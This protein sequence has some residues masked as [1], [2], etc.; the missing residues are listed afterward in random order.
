MGKLVQLASALMTTMMV[1]TSTLVTESPRVDLWEFCCSP[2]SNLTSEVTAVGL[3]SE[4]INFQSRFD[5]YKDNT[6]DKLKEKYI[7]ER[8]RRLWIS[9]PCTLRCPW[10]RINYFGR[11]HVL[12]ARRRK[13]RRM[14]NKVVNTIEDMLKEI[15]DREVY[16]EWPKWAEGWKLHVIDEKL[17]KVLEHGGKMIYNSYVDG[18]RYGMK[19]D[20]G[21][22]FIRKSWRVRTTDA[23]FHKP[24]GSKLCTGGHQHAEIAGRQTALTAYYPKAWCRAIARNFLPNT[25]RLVNM[26][27]PN[28]NLHD[29]QQGATDYIEDD[30]MNELNYGDVKFDV[31][32]PTPQLREEWLAR[33]RHYHRAGGHHI[34]QPDLPPDC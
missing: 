3:N 29:Q 19:D 20:K 8:P 15:P 28:N 4:R 9:V 7:I 24:F 30:F 11:E 33:I 34:P 27:E 13:D 26:L 23:H 22:K 16:W 17:N 31:D 6:Y 5:V 25:S 32:E 2:H 10:Q 21:E 14:L 12:Q 1:L 18:C